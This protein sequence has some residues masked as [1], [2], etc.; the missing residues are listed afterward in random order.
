MA[1]P[2]DFTRIQFTPASDADRERG[3][4]GF[5]RVVLDGL[6]VLDGLTLRRT[7]DKFTLSY[8]EREDGLG[9]RH[10]IIRPA[11]DDACRAIE[12]GILGALG[13]RRRS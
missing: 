4:L 10:P 1:E 6:L 3:L 13:W 8:P 5:I 7:R 12:A 11:D 2:P 9:R